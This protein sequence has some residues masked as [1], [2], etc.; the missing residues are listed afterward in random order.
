MSDAGIDTQAAALILDGYRQVHRRIAIELATLNPAL[1]H[2][3]PA[4]GANSVAI[5][6]RHT[7]GSE[8]DVLRAVAGQ[9]SDRDRAVEFRASADDD[10]T[11]LRAALAAADRLLD[12]LGPRLTAEHL[13]VT[14]ERPPRP[15]RTGLGWLIENYCHAREHLAHLELTRQIL[16]AAR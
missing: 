2:L 5:L 7:L 4:P 9:P 16:E 1:L 10:P 8:G 3:A 14:V 15:S 13:R 6:I 11:D 12:T